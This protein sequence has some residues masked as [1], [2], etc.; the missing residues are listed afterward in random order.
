MKYHIP[1]LLKESIE[2]LNIQPDGVYVDLTFGGGGHS[3]EILRILDKGRLIAF[4]QD[5]SAERNRPADDRFLFF[6]QNFRFLRN[7]LRYAGVDSVD[8]LI[9]DLG[10]SFHQFDKPDRGFSFRYNTPLDM[11]MNKNSKRIASEVIKSYSFDDLKRILSEYGELKN[12]GRIA[13][14]IEDA[15]IESPI[16]TAG[17]LVK[18]LEGIVP[19]KGEN[20]FYAKVFQALRIE[21]NREIECLK[22]ML[23]QS[24]EVLKVGGKFVVITYHSLEDRVVKNFFRAGNF[25]G[26]E[27]KDF[28]GNLIV[29]LRQVNRHV[30]VPSEEEIKGNSRA[31]SAKLRIA[32][33][34]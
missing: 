30:I 27:Q 29:P 18:V 17:D 13:R 3:A 25:D 24:L 2:G 7:V 14:I 34:I 6:N 20:K 26:I 5:E 4:D 32:E 15:R 21:V 10:V 28:Y 8:G 19:A 9:A 12:A 1:A 16:V 23:T 31:R 11:R 33:R 22:E